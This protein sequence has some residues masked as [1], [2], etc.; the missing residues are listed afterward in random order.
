MRHL[1]SFLLIIAFATGSAAQAAAPSDLPAFGTGA[2]PRVMLQFDNSR[3]MLLAPDPLSN[4]LGDLTYAGD[5][6]DPDNNPGAS[7]GN[8]L[9]IGKRVMS[10]VIPAYA[11]LMEM[12]LATYYQ[13]QRTYIIPTGGGTTTCWYDVLAAPGEIRSFYSY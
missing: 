1:S 7:C 5:D 3:S 12:G 6:Y 13:F 8:K 4:V 2:K 10:Q 9:C 11:S